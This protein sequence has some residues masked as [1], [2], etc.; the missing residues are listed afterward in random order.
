L[1]GF[2]G[3]DGSRRVLHV[4]E[5]GEIVDSLDARSASFWL[6]APASLS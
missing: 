6:T 2:V 5:A 1:I 4:N 3:S